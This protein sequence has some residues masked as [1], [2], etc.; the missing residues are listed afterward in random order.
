[1]P[2]FGAGFTG[3]G[4]GAD[5]F[6]T[7]GFAAGLVVSFATAL[8]SFT[9]ADAFG[10]GLAGAFG[11]A[12]FAPAFGAGKALGFA[13][14]AVRTVGEAFFAAACATR[15]FAAGFTLVLGALRTPAPA[16]AFSFAVAIW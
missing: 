4:F 1:L 15:A 10:A 11:F 9:G 12:P 16:L 8:T 6:A 13:R 2:A 3:A 14:A 7:T 5:A